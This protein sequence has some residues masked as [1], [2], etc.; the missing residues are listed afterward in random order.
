MYVSVCSKYV[1][2]KAEIPILSLLPTGPASIFYIENNAEKPLSAP[3]KS[4]R[5][6]Q[7]HF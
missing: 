3:S 2:G 1:G 5:K 7:D 6:N 4:I